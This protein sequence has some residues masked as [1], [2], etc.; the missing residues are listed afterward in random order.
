MRNNFSDYGHS[1]KCLMKRYRIDELEELSE[2]KKSDDENK[3]QFIDRIAKKLQNQYYV[4][5]V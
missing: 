4:N 1:W 5:Y 3:S 2:M